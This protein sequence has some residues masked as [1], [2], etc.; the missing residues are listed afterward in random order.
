LKVIH[1]A[2]KNG[3]EPPFVATAIR[4]DLDG[5]KRARWRVITALR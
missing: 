3:L 5:R 4:G 2:M 1:A